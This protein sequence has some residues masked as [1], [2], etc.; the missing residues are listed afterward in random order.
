MASKRGLAAQQKDKEILPARKSLRLQGIDADTGL[1]LPEKEPT[2]YFMYGS[3]PEEYSRPPL[4]DLELNEI[5]SSKDK[6]GEDDNISKYLTDI[7]HCMKV[8]KED[9]DNYFGD[10]VSRRLKELQITV[11]SVTKMGQ[12]LYSCPFIKLLAPRF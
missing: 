3:T 6:G 9:K 2:S 7:L 4:R 5:L 8:K 1:Q 11:S 12:I 10:N